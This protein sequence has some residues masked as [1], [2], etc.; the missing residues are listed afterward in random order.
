MSRGEEENE[1]GMCNKGG[2]MGWIRRTNPFLPLFWWMRVKV[3]YPPIQPV[4]TCL[5]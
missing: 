2:K 1:V 3:L 4:L 5:A